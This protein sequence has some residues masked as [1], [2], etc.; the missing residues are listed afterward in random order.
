MYCTTKADENE[1][2]YPTSNALTRSGERVGV[3][4]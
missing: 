2:R 1:R 3:N 4:T